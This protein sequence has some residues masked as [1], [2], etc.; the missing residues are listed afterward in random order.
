MTGNN[1]LAIDTLQK[2]LRAAGPTTAAWLRIDP[3]W[4]NLRGEARFESLLKEPDVI[5]PTAAPAER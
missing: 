2:V 4:A 1:T 3:A 5:D